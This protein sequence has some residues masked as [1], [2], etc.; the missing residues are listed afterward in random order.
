MVFL[1]GLSKAHKRL[2]NMIEYRVV[3]ATHLPK[4]LFFPHKGPGAHY[5][6]PRRG[7]AP[8]RAQGRSRGD[9]DAVLEKASASAGQGAALRPD[10]PSVNTKKGGLGNRNPNPLV[11]VQG[12][13]A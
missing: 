2:L 13:R 1:L 10:P 6:A 11:I 4:A 3:S 9:W 7:A 8:G 5:R 12:N